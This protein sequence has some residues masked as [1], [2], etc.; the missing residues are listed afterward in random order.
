MRRGRCLT[1]YWHRDE[2]IV[3][4]YSHSTPVTLPAATAEIMEDR[5]RPA[6]FTSYLDADRVLL[7]RTPAK[8]D[9]PL[10]DAL[11]QRRTT[12]DFGAEPVQLSR[13]AALLATVFGPVDFIYAGG[14]G[15]LIRRTSPSGGARQ[16]LG[17]YVAVRNVSDMA[18]G[19][20]HYNAREHSLELLSEGCDRDELAAACGNQEW[21]GGAAFVICLVA[22]VERMLVKYRNPRVPRLSPRRGPLRA[23]LRT[24]RHRAGARSF[25]DR[26]L[27][28][29]PRH[30]VPRPGRYVRRTTLSGRP[31]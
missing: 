25:P 6:I 29:Q 19:W 4:P 27:R 17:A 14:F 30:R 13:L 2:F 12:R 8:L 28:R 5:G 18:P 24:D 16:E 11:Y 22:E 23:E 3:R 10:G 7:P 20:Y 21:A 9:T 15:A 26:R 1:C 31:R